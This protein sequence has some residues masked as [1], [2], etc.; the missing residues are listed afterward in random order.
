MNFKIA[1]IG[2]QA[3]G[4]D[5]VAVFR[6]FKSETAN[7]VVHAGDFEYDDNPAAWDTLINNNFGED[8]PYFACTGNHDKDRYYGEGCYPEFMPARMNRLGITWD[9]DPGVRSSLKYN[10]IFFVLTAPGTLDESDSRG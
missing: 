1:F 9:G 6:L 3:L 10:G 7:A 2:D 5:A 8:L 4:E